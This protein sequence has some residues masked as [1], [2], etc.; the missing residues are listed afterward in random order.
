[1]CIERIIADNIKLEARNGFVKFVRRH[2]GGE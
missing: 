2:R 1:M